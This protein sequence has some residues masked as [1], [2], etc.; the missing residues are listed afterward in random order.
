[1]RFLVKKKGGNIKRAHEKTFATKLFCFAYIFEMIVI[2][3]Q[4]S[5]VPKN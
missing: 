2:V 4:N 1:M 3:E 5:Q